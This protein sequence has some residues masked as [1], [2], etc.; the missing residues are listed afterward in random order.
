MS[1][2]DIRDRQDY[3]MVNEMSTH[4][5]LGFASLTFFMAWNTPSCIF[6]LGGGGGDIIIAATTQQQGG[7]GVPKPAPRRARARFRRPVFFSRQRA[8]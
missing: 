4:F 5:A 3:V 2:N 8:P 7:F 1:N 6:L